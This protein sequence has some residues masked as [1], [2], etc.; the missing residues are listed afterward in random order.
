MVG[1]TCAIPMRFQPCPS[2]CIHISCP[3]A[4]LSAPT[5]LA[6]SCAVDVVL[7]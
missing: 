4:G 3:P 7:A 5:A 2:D 1:K 6:E